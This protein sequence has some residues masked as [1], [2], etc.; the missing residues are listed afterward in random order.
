MSK[1]NKVFI[2]IR[3]ENQYLVKI[4]NIKVAEGTEDIMIICEIKHNS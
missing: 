4:K 3:P 2:F 1:K